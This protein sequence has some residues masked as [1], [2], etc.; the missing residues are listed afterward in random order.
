VAK[1]LIQRIAAVEIRGLEDDRLTAAEAKSGHRVLVTHAAR[2]AQYVIKRVVVGCVIPQPATACSKTQHRRVYGGDGTE[3]C[4][5]IPTKYH[6]FMIVKRGITE[7]R[8]DAPSA[9]LR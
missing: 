1:L 9:L 8:H 6:P 2:Q 3:A 5:R 4:R 7:G